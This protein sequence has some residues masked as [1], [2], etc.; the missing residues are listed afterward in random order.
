MRCWVTMIGSSPM[1]SGGKAGGTVARG[2]MGEKVRTDA[3]ARCIAA[4][5]SPPPIRDATTRSS[6]AKMCM[7]GDPLLGQPRDRGCPCCVP[8][9]RRDRLSEFLAV[10]HAVAARWSDQ[11]TVSG[12]GQGGVRTSDQTAFV[13]QI[14]DVN[15]DRVDNVLQA[16]V[17]VHRRIA[18]EEDAVLIEA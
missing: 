2:V 10:R 8:A 6:V 12:Q 17:E 7:V 14:L 4:R 16:G 3:Q 13:G 5:A 1:T 9:G 18:R 15:I 11:K